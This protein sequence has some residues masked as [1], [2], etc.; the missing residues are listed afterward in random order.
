[1]GNGEGGEGVGEGAATAV[2]MAVAKTPATVGWWDGGGEGAG[3]GGVAKEGRR[4]DGDGE[5]VA[6]GTRL[7]VR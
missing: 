7:E 2:V 6:G 4:G 1:M 3:E 5:R